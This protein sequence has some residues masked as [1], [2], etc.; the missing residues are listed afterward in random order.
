MQQDMQQQCVQHDIMNLG[1]VTHKQLRRSAPPLETWCIMEYA[2]KGSLAD[3]LQ[4]RGRLKRAGTRGR[5]LLSAIKCLQDIVEGA[6]KLLGTRYCCRAPLW[7]A[8]KTRSPS[9]AGP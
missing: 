9:S 2:A 6:E 8:D 4:R 3:L 7:H 5:D 1:T